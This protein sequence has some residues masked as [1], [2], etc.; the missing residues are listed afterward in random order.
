LAVSKFAFG[1]CLAQDP[2]DLLIIA[3]A[4]CS[5]MSES[6]RLLLDA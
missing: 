3:L 5:G 6:K 4:F 1:Q 2:L